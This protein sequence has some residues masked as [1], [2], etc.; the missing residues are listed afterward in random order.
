MSLTLILLLFVCHWIA[1]YTHLQTSWMLKAKMKGSP[2]FPIF[3]H[4]LAHTVLMAICLIF[5]TSGQTLLLVLAIELVS[6]FL[7]DVWKGKMNIWFPSIASPTNQ[8]HWI[9]FGFDQMLHH[10]IILIMAWYISMHG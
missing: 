10:T 1:D 6:H 4:A 9:V 2:F 5:F 3:I 7:I 8:W